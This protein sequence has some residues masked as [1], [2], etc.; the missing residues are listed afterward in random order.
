MT[1]DTLQVSFCVII[2]CFSPYICVSNLHVLY[3]PSLFLAVL[4]I[5]NVFTFR[6]FLTNLDE[7]VFPFMRYYPV[8]LR[9]LLKCFLHR[10]LSQRSDGHLQADFNVQSQ[11][12]KQNHF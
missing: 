11:I 4:R 12:G 10:A 9:I 2:N 7:C 5:N 8:F 3:Q 1:T 6:F